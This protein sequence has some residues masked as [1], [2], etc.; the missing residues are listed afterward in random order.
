MFHA[1]VMSN[2]Y[3]KFTFFKFDVILEIM[4]RLGVLYEENVILY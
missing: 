2:F 4:K 1:F 3:I